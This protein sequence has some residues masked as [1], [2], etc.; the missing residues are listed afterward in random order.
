MKWTP[1]VLLLLLVNASFAQWPPQLQQLRAHLLEKNY[2]DSLGARNVL[3]DS[4][5]FQ[6]LQP[7]YRQLM[8]FPANGKKNALLN[9]QIA[10]NDFCFAGDHATAMALA[11]G[12]YDSLPPQAYVDTRKFIDSL[13]GIR[14]VEAKK[15]ILERTAQTRVVMLNESHAFSQHRA[16]ALSLLEELYR[17][18][19]HY[20]ALEWLNSRVGRNSNSVDIRTGYYSAEPVAGEFI[21][22]AL[23]IGF[24]LLPY[25]DS[26]GNKQV[27]SGREAVQAA[28]LSSLLQQDS[29]AKLLVLASGA[30]I[31]EKQVGNDYTPMA[32]FFKRFTG[33]DPL[34]ID[35][36]EMCEG[37]AF[38]Y[39]RYFYAS[40]VKKYPIDTAVI[41][42]RGQEPYSLLENDQY[43]LQ[44]IHPIAKWK[45]RRPT[46]LDLD[47]KRKEWP[48]R[49]TE[50]KLFLVQAYYLSESN[51]KPIGVLV[52]A[53]QT[54]ISDEDGYYWL[55]LY[56]GKY[57]L[58]MRDGEY[59]QLSEK[60]IV[61][62]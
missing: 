40:W 27:G 58:V 8:A 52:P 47:R 49:P 35:Q 20:L 55:Y 36:T 26:I 5:G 45:H 62:Q 29:S 41:A 43:D 25:E 33:I 3:Y 16:F 34:T 12:N 38:E 24:K 28:A 22:K 54:Y 30:H 17:Q 23:S 57:K 1:V 2:K 10:A 51:S 44:V 4:K 42:F 32:L 21:R 15:T 11:A 7:I 9:Y 6:Y 39:G 31:S 60:E 46:W 19:F 56:P 37:S 61:V 14:L 53:D 13:Q 18:G 48:V 50:Q 59:N